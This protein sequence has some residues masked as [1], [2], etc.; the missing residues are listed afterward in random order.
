MINRAI[1]ANPFN[2]VIV[3][4]ML[5]IAWMG[6]TQLCKLFCSKEIKEN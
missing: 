3:L 2:W 4:L 6:A 1:I 5:I